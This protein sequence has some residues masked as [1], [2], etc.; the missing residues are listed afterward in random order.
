MVALKVGHGGNVGGWL[1]A[2]REYL[3]GAEGAV[4][5]AELVNGLGMRVLEE[6]TWEQAWGG[7]GWSSGVGSVGVKFDWVW[8]QY[9]AKYYKAHK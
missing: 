9:I 8:K 4:S 3:G 6:W 2:I 1:G 5:I 7:F